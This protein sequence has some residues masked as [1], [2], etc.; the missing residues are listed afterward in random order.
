M[1]KGLVIAPTRELANQ[2]YEEA[3][4]FSYRTYVRPCVIYGGAPEGNQ[5]RDLGRGCDL[6]IATPGRL[7]DFMERDI[8]NLTQAQYLVLDEADR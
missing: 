8:V 2:I 5:I 1:P 7:I 3:L 4:K 6:L